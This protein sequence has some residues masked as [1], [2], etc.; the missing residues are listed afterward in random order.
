MSETISPGGIVA[1]LQLC[2]GHRK[3]MTKVVEA[4][5]IENL[6]LKGDR[7]AL[8]D[9]SRQILLLEKETVD[10]LGIKPGDVKENITT[11][12]ISLMTLPSKQ[13]IRI[14]KEVTVEVTKPCSPCSRMDEIRS[15]L[16]RE[17]AGRRGILVRVIRGGTIRVGD[18]IQLIGG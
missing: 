12:G 17:I 13:Q 6:G 16:L 18:A 10:E 1:S 2:P 8:R 15:G 4:E 3:P 14:G 5:A 7:H 9:S 11:S